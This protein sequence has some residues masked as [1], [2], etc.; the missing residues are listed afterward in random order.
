MNVVL[1][2]RFLFRFWG[3]DKT[4][5][6]GAIKFEVMARSKRLEVATYCGA[7]GATACTVTMLLPVV[8]GT[9]AASISGS[10]AGMANGTYTI[11]F[12]GVFLLIAQPLMIA[13]LGL[14]L[15]GMRN[16]GRLALIISAVGG[17]LLYAAMFIFGVSLPLIV[18]SSLILA[19]GYGVAYGPLVIRRMK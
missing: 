13:S 11:P 7:V 17:V 16:F 18:L 4:I 8:I 14:I 2:Q 10:M 9:T 19:V 15:Y 5:R 6:N 12:L 1:S 3:T